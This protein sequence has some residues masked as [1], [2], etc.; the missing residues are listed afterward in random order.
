MQPVLLEVFTNQEDESNAL[1]IVDHLLSSTR[2]VAIRKA[3]NIA[4]KLLPQSVIDELKKH[5]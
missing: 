1:Y 2:Q 3:K 4:K 5:V